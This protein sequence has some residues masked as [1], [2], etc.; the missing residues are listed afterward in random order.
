MAIENNNIFLGSGA[1][2][3]LIPEVDFWFQPAT[4]STTVIQFL[5]ST[6]AQFQLVN[7]MYVGCT[8]DFYDNTLYVSPTPS[9]NY[10]LESN[11]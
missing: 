7:D 5:Q 6:L 2:L 10:T 4:T 1:S 11:K 8:I 9:S 3:T